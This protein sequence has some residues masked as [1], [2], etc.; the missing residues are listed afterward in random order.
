MAEGAAHVNK[1]AGLFNARS[2]GHR[3]NLS[4]TSDTLSLTEYI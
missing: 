1:E 2:M 4:P 3:E